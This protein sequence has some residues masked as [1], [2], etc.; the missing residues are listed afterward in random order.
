MQGTAKGDVALNIPFTD[1][2]IALQGEATGNLGAVGLEGKAH[3]GKT[4]KGGFV[5]VQKLELLHC[6]VENWDLALRL[7]KTMIKRL[8][9]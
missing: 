6:L 1:Y 7:E 5:L 2:Q 3:L 4:K 9:L 8:H